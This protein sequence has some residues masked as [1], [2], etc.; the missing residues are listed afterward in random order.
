VDVRR[1]FLTA[2]PQERPPWWWIPTRARRALLTLGCLAPILAIVVVVLP[3]SPAAR[4]ATGL[5]RASFPA[6]LQQAIRAVEHPGRLQAPPTQPPAPPAAPVATP[7][8]ATTSTGPSAPAPAPQGS[9]DTSS[10]AAWAAS[11]G[12]ACI[13]QH[14]SGNDYGA[15]TGNGYYGA[16]QD[17]LSTWQA[18]GGTGLPSDAPPAVQDQI[19][20]QIWLSG[21][22]GQWGTASLC[23]Q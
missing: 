9:V 5:E 3:G 11:P 15:N 16:Y 23:G 2:R 7:A 6:P 17:Q 18:A 4:G 12:V 14:E 20:Y 8:A 10:A 19:N 1:I 13:R 21:G 22:W